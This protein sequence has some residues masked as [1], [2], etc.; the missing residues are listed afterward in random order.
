MLRKY[1]LVIY[2]YLKYYLEIKI[3]IGMEKYAL[4]WLRCW[5][6]VCVSFNYILNNKN[7]DSDYLLKTV[8]IEIVFCHLFLS[9]LLP[10]D[11]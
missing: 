1:C 10:W 3:Q 4:N 11:N 9:K 8:I 5:Y 6:S 2:F 7:W